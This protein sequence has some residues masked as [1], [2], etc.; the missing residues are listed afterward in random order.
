M[1]AGMDRLFADFERALRELGKQELVEAQSHLNRLRE[2]PRISAAT[3]Q[4]SVQDLRTIAT[5]VLIRPSRTS[6]SAWSIE[7]AQRGG[8]PAKRLGGQ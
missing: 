6:F 1:L 7:V 2:G 3:V 4:G 8:L 5:E